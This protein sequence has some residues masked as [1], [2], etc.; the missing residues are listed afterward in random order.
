MP[1]QTTVKDFI[2]YPDGAKVSVKANGESVFTDL[3]VIMSDCQATLTYTENQVDTANAD[4]L[5]KQL[6]DLQMEGTFELGN[7]DP[8]NIE[9]LSGGLMT[10]VDT[11]ASPVA[12]I[13]DQT[14]SASWADQTRYELVLETSS[15][16]T[17][18]LKTTS[19]P[20]LTS[21]TLDP[22]GTPE[23]LVEDSEYIVVADSNSYSGWSIVFISSNMST[24]TPTDYEIVID[25]GSNTPVATETLYCGTSTVVLDAYEMKWVHTDSN[26]LERSLTFYKVDGTSGG[27]Q[28]NFKGSNSEG[29]ETMPLS[30]MARLDTDR[31]DGRQLFEWGIDNG[32]A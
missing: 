19:A 11:A 22:T 26:G 7:L 32:A 1:A 24:V 30:F 21:V 17:T 18:K 29:I 25:Y 10:K 15:S 27:F 13:P 2:F 4:K 12:T 3:G 14:I 31:T 9:R 28:F 8:A 20:T 16:D 6:K 23:V 5:D